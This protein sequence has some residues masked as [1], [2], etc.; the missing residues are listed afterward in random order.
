[1]R[2]MNQAGTPRLL[3]YV[4]LRVGP[5]VYAL[6][7]QSAKF[8]RDSQTAPGGFFVE[9]HDGEL[10]IMVDDDASPGEVQAQIARASAEAVKHIS[11][12][13]LN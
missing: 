3:G 7:V 1:M 2:E 9:D 4:Q 11:K 5:K 6:P 12:K 8:D 13:F 10:G